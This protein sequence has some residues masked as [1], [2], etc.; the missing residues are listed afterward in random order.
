[1]NDLITISFPIY[2]VAKTIKNSLQSV[3]N[4]SYPN[5]ELILIDDCGTDNSI[6]IMHEILKTTQ[7]NFI[8]KIIKHPQNLGLGEARNTS[9]KNATGKYIY[10]MDSDDILSTNCIE[11]LHRTMQQHQTDFV[12]ASYATFETNIL[13]KIDY[14]YPEKKILNNNHEILEHYFTQKK[15]IFVFMWNKL[16]STSFLRKNHIQCIHPI[17]EDDLF[18]FQVLLHA[19][20]CC[21][22]P[23]ITY[24]YYINPTSITNQQMKKNIPPYTGKIFRDIAFCK[25]KQIEHLKT[26]QSL[27]IQLSIFIESLFRGKRILQSSRIPP[28]EKKELL[29]SLFNIPRLHLNFQTWVK[30]PLKTKG[31]AILYKIFY[32][33]NQTSNNLLL[34]LLIKND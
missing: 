18:L 9:I 33:G 11:L 26:T 32:H 17:V 23:D 16:Y 13:Q 24:F 6:S 28:K 31:K 25:Y 20:S 3:L 10:F 15:K 29:Q 4:Q 27:F 8:I 22:I 14:T 7:N 1:M 19:N 5:I 2:N 30:L 21:L 34:R 12:A